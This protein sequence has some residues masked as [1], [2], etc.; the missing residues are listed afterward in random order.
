VEERKRRIQVPG[1][2]EVDGTEVGFRTSG[3]NWSEY[4]ADDGSVI[5]IKIVATDIVRVD[6]HY[7]EEGNPIYRVRTQNVMVVSA[8]EDLR[9]QS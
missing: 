8:P 5:R 6:G 3:E 2:G 7:D 1:L 4:L 9:R